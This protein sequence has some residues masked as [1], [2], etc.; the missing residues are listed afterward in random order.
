MNRAGWLLAG[1]LGVVACGG[2]AEADPA[3][4]PQRRGPQG[5]IA[6]FVVE[7]EFSHTAFD[8]PIVA[9][10]RPGA[11]HQHQFFGNEAVD[12]DAEYDTALGSAT[13]CDQPLD[14]AS[15]WTPTLHD[16]QGRV[17]EPLG[18]TAYYRPGPGIDPADVE[19]YPAGL[20]MV[21]GEPGAES[22]QSTDVV[23]WSC[24]TGA[25]RD[26]E[27]PACP[28][29][30]S[31]R[32]LVTFPECWDAKRLTGFGTGAHVRYSDGGCP[33]DFP[34][35]IPQL[36]VAVDF[37]PVDPEG[38]SLSS[39]SVLTGHADFWNVWDQDKLEREV[40]LCINRDLVCGV[41]S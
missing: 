27:P 7:C 2:V 32:M 28:E 40:E 15:Y 3:P 21:A 12:A 5:R 20:M 6:Q 39:G 24:G 9:P 17:V 30:S 4:D 36:T 26:P 37:P 34:I 35:A 13:T 16:A 31:L 41:S 14:T 11:S 25:I 19:P 38:L 29:G 23:A 22:P 10:G 8:D 1:A 18:L 33:D